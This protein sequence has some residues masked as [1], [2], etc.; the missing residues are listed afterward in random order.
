MRLYCNTAL[1]VLVQSVDNNWKKLEKLKK[2]TDTLQNNQKKLLTAQLL[3]IQRREQ[4]ALDEER[5]RQLE[6]DAANAEAERLRLL[7]EEQRR[8]LEEQ[9]RLRRLREEEEAAR[10]LEDER[11]KRMMEE[12]ERLRRL[13][14]EEEE[15]RRRQLEEEEMRRRQQ[16]LEELEARLKAEREKIEEVEDQWRAFTWDDKPWDGEYAGVMI[17]CLT[18]PALLAG[19]IRDPRKIADI[20][21]R[22]KMMAEIRA[23]LKEEAK[24]M[25]Y[26]TKAIE[27]MVRKAKEAEEKRWAQQNTEWVNDKVAY[28]P[29]DLICSTHEASFGPTSRMTLEES[30]KLAAER[31]ISR[32]TVAPVTL[33]VR[34]PFNLIST[35][36]YKASI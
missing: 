10:F 15:R 13:R 17:G 3:E 14:E 29:A 30:R 21:R 32:S 19:M 4:E 27:E 31:K 7:A 33:K 6:I 36:A 11:R 26:I 22:A 34:L 18:N 24:K 1:Q 9:E 12:E 35:R 20:L 16:E 2:E 8:L 23:K 28:R 5:R 25:E